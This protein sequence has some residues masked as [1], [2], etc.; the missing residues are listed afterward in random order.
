[1]LEGIPRRR[2]LVPVQG[3]KMG[4]PDIYPFLE[5]ALDDDDVM[6]E[7]EPYK[8]NGGVTGRK[9]FD[10]AETLRIVME[11][12]DTRGGNIRKLLVKAHQAEEE[13][14]KGYLLSEVGNKLYTALRRRYQLDKKG[15]V[16]GPNVKH[17]ALLNHD[18]PAA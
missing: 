6:T 10:D 4:R 5:A 15:K 7:I 2:D 1:M 9:A 11:F 17:Y 14:S 18:K 12:D 13:R 16:T 3:S 8:L